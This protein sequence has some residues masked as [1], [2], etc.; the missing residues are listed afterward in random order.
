MGGK[1]RQQIEP[2]N[3]TDV[4]RLRIISIKRYA[5]KTYF[6]CID[7]D[8]KVLTG[9]ADNSLLSDDLGPNSIIEFTKSDSQ[10]SSDVIFKGIE[11]SKADSHIRVVGEDTS[12]PRYT[13]LPVTKIRDITSDRKYY[14]LIVNV[15][16]CTRGIIR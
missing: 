11:I 7:K 1:T 5:E 10:D 13:D 15:V 9:V 16:P 2:Q 4:E 6:L 3:K 8:T 14:V 12:F